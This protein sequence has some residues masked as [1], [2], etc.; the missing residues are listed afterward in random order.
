MFACKDIFA[1]CTK[2]HARRARRRRPGGRREGLRSKTSVRN[3]PQAKM[4][5]CKDIFA[6]CTKKHARRAR[7]RRPGGRRE[8]LRSKT[9]VRNIPQAKMFACK[10]IFAPCTKEHARRARRRRPGGRCEGLRSKTS[11]RIITHF[12]RIHNSFFRFSGMFTNFSPVN[13]ASEQILSVNY[14]KAID[15]HV[16]V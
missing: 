15:N 14:Q 4:F 8:G 2:K 7:R 5:A 3:I 10:D 11:V 9:S 6:P 13:P 1:P 16:N 12:S